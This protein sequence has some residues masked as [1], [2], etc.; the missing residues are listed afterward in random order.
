MYRCHLFIPVTGT[1]NN[2]ENTLVLSMQIILY[3]SVHLYPKQSSEVEII[4]KMRV[5]AVTME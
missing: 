2:I 1:I 5:T 3:P 4:L